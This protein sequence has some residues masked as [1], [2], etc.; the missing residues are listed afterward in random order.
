M[1]CWA[2]WLAGL[3]PREVQIYTIDRQPAEADVR[4]VQPAQLEEIACTLRERTGIQA[5]ICT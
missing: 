3:R 4:P 2:G 1:L 5:R